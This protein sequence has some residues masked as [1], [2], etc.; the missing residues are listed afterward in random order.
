MNAR[1]AHPVEIAHSR[2][3]IRRP[4]IFTPLEQATHHLAQV[5]AT[6]CPVDDDSL[7]S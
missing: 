2:T 4:F 5:A 3:S 1:T 7:L 6:R